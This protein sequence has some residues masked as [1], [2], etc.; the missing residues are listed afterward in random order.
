MTPMVPEISI[1]IPTL[2]DLQNL[3]RLVK[4]ILIQNLD[5][6]KFEVLIIVNGLIEN[7]KKDILIQWSV[8]FQ[9]FLK[10]HFLP[11]KGVNLA[12]NFGLNNAKS[13]ILLFLDDDCELPNAHFFTEHIQFHRKN[14][15]VFATGGGYILP[16]AAA[17]FDEIYNYLQ[18]KW[19]AS[20]I[21]TDRTV[22][23]TRHLIGGNF[24]IKA[25]MAKMK[26]L[27]FDN[28]I[29]YGGSEF[30]FF[31]RAHRARLEMITNDWD[32]IH[33]TQESLRGLTRKIYKQGRGKAHIDSQLQTF[34]DNAKKEI[35][36]K[37]EYNKGS[38]VDEYFFRLYFN[39]VFWTGYYFF[40]K[41]YLNLFFHIGVDLLRGI[42]GLRFELLNKISKQINHKKEKGD[43]F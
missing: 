18:M 24:S 19:F 16:S 35:D 36:I 20:G 7:N 41:K 3:E 39:Y 27:Y 38:G 33:H 23:K 30:E 4:S 14:V 1:I 5:K 9:D 32:V 2:G 43:R 13:N 40:Q 15:Q 37:K 21:Y 8:S 12:R 29:V 11:Q 22:E 31:R 26:E 28:F 34:P 25:E 6:P 42:N 17:Y 10:L